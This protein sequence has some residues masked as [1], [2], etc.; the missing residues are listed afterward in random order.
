MSKRRGRKRDNA[1][2]EPIAGTSPGDRRKRLLTVGVLLLFA[3]LIAAQRLHTYNEELERDIPC[4]AVIGHEMLQGRELYTDLWDNKPPALHVTYAAAEAVAGY[5]PRAIYLLNVAF[6]VVILL[7]VY[8]AGRAAGGG[9]AGGLWAAAFWTVIGGD[10]FLQ[11]NQPNTE[12]MINACRIWAFVLMLRSEDRKRGPLYWLGIGALFAL[13]TLYKQIIIFTAVG[14]TFVHLLFGRFRRRALGQAGLATAAAAFVWTYVFVYFYSQGRGPFFLGAVFLYNTEYAGHQ[15]MNVLRG[16]T[17]ILLAPK[18]LW[19]AWPLAALTLTAFVGAARKFPR[20]TAMLAALIVATIIEISLP[21]KFFPHYYQY[22]LPVLC[23][24]AAWGAEA[25][26]RAC[27]ARFGAAAPHVAAAF[28]LVC[29]LIHEAPFYRLSATEWSRLKYGDQFV[30]SARFAREID[31]LLLPN[32]TFYVWGSAPE[33]YYYTRRSPP[34][35]VLYSDPL[36]TGPEVLDLSVRTLIYVARVNPE[37]FIVRL[38]DDQV[39]GHLRDHPV[40]RWFM[41]RYHPLPDRPFRYGF[42]IF[43]RTG[44]ALDRRLGGDR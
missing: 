17:P 33:L 29:L 40:S 41:E 4:Y 32:E 31:R 39:F 30:N 15:G 9:T 43:V 37:L 10:L 11:A 19:F 34:C 25:L 3:L 18:T 6:G 38:E 7:G 13:A 42:A 28:A 22:W 2:R 26:R 27:P 23:V 24:G 35:G 21:G 5:G 1:R 12:L 16:L 20:E 14:L 44:G 36:N 8:A